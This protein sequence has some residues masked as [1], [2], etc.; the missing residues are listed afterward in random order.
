[1]TIL[2]GSVQ[3]TLDASCSLFRSVCPP[4]ENGMVKAFVGTISLAKLNLVT[5]FAEKLL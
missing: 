5:Y 4:I 1:M 2:L 3:G